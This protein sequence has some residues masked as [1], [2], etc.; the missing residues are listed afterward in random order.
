MLPVPLWI[1][2]WD[3]SSCP[4]ALCLPGDP[5]WG[6][7]AGHLAGLSP[8]PHFQCRAGVLSPRPGSGLA[9]VHWGPLASL[10]G[11]DTEIRPV[12]VLAQCKHLSP[13]M[14]AWGP[15]SPQGYASAGLN[16]QLGHSWPGD[17]RG[18]PVSLEEHQGQ[19]Q[20][21]LQ[22]SSRPPTPVSKPTG[23]A[24][25]A[26]AEGPAQG[27]AAGR[28]GGS[29]HAPEQSRGEARTWPCKDACAHPAPVQT[30]PRGH[31]EARGRGA[32][33]ALPGS[34]RTRNSV[35]QMPSQKT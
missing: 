26:C 35:A 34:L 20:P 16:V 10:G 9:P 19:G 15:W 23:P 6:G 25:A 7:S 1:P 13:A 3:E 2:R 18:T 33:T 14:A 29:G 5:V 31:G 32:H 27:S 8:S 21:S 28:A 12:S 4:D 11:S 22:P 24:G 17:I 30:R